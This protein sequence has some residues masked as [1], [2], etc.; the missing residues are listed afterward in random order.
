VAPRSVSW[1]PYP[2]DNYENLGN[3]VQDFIWPVS[4]LLIILYNKALADCC[5]DPRP[6]LP[7]QRLHNRRN[8][9]IQ[10]RH[11]RR[12]PDACGQCANVQSDCIR[13]YRIRNWCRVRI[14]CCRER[15]WVYQTGDSGY[16]RRLVAVDCPG[17]GGLFE[18]GVE[19]YHVSNLISQQSVGRMILMLCIDS[20]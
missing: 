16:G 18:M 19:C 15:R 14:L 12:K 20:L 7:H 5:I 3:L 2:N 9:D 10:L 4:Y 17:F 11:P 8:R 1:D 6:L 13:Q